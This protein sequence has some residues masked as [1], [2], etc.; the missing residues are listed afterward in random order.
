MALLNIENRKK[1]FEYLQLGEYNAK[2][3]KKFQK[4]AFPHDKD[5]W[6]G[7][8][9]QHTD[10][11]LRTIYN[12]KRF[13]GG[14]FEPE[15]FTC[16]CGRCCGYP[17]FLKKV[18]IQHL[19]R[20][21]KHWNKPM[22]ITSGMRCSFENSRSGGVA[23]SGHLRGY[24]CDFY[25]KGVTET[26][27]ERQKSMK[28]I[29]KQVNHKFT[30]GAFMKGSDGVYRTAS[31]MGNAMHTETQAPKK[32]TKKTKKKTTNKVAAV[33]NAIA[34]KAKEY[35]YPTNTSKANYNGGQ[36]TE[37]YKK[38]LDE[39]YPKRNSWGV[40]PRKG[41]SCDVFVGTCVRNSGIDKSFPRGLDEQWEHLKKSDKFALVKNPTVNN[42][43]D[44]DI[45]TY[46]KSSGG[47]HIC[48]V[49]DGKIK[50]AGYRHYYPK[51]TNYLKQRLSTKG[52]R[53]LKVYRVKSK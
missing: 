27:S 8:Y 28:W 23:N 32:T 29:V 51:T 24:A 37:A 38:G 53:W 13:G 3:I 5:E 19:V 20:I 43:Q 16:K 1:R 50:E 31:G 15:E 42:V 39:A 45:I 40:A 41:A 7:I 9:G 18:Q 12:V 2:N 17:T 10:N 49:C 52:K 11:A 47:G 44:G 26:V 48:I 30:Y 25:M 21:R 36:P 34:K 4:T 33:T 22:H 35:A 6:D 14:F 46:I